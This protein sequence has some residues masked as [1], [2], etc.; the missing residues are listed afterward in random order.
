MV[1]QS[2][3][4]PLRS[5]VRLLVLVQHLVALLNIS[6][7]CRTTI[8]YYACLY[9]IFPSKL[10]HSPF[11][12]ACSYLGLLL[13]EHSGCILH[14]RI[15][16]CCL[17][18]TL[19]RAPSSPLPPPRYTR[20]LIHPSIHPIRSSFHFGFLMIYGQ[21]VFCPFDNATSHFTGCSSA[22]THPPPKACTKVFIGSSIPLCY[23]TY[24]VLRSS[25]LYRTYAVLSLF[26]FAF[27][28][29]ISHSGNRPR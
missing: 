3:T 16:T 9:V 2:T 15:D 28:Q 4:L 1:D 17:Q 7:F 8:I 13:P 11:C 10:F 24:V 29:P 5:C 12:F 21:Y 25:R 22:R 20:P 19:I 18:S 14:L 23:F 6:Y 26:F 27:S